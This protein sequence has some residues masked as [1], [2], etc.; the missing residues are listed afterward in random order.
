M[1]RLRILAGPSLDD[2]TPIEANSGV[3]IHIKSDAFDGQIVV[4]IKGFADINGNVS[5]SSYFEQKERKGVTW[6][7]Q[8]QGPLFFPALLSAH[9]ST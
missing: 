8:A 2:L 3:P 1:T 4:H 5:H 7:I 9:N 6:S